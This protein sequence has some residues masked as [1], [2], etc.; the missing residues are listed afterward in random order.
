MHE[1]RVFPPSPYCRDDSNPVTSL[2][3]GETWKLETKEYG[4]VSCCTYIMPRL[5]V[6]HSPIF[7]PR[8]RFRGHVMNQGNIANIKSMTML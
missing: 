3:A 7:S 5:K 4:I 2:S 1:W 6:M 8:L